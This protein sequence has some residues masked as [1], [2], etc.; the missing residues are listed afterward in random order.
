MEDGGEWIVAARSSR[1]SSVKPSSRESVRIKGKN[2]SMSD[3]FVLEAKREREEGGT[4]SRVRE[5]EIQRVGKSVSEEEKDPMIARGQKASTSTSSQPIISNKKKNKPTKN[6]G[7]FDLIEAQLL[8][9][10]PK[11]K[12]SQSLSHNSHHQNHTTSNLN[13]KKLPTMVEKVKVMKM[14]SDQ[15]TNANEFIVVK[16]QHKKKLST[17]KKRILLVCWSL[18]NSPFLTLM[19]LGTPTSS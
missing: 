12:I 7:L 6:L 17:L 1:K 13:E 3:P 19:S 14:K 11:K 9:N 4:T 5:K 8:T 16:K 10:V 18:P 15:P 2:G